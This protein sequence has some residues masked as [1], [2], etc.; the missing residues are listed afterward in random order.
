[1]EQSDFSEPMVRINT[2]PAAGANRWSETQA[3][4]DIASFYRQA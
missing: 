4:D 3:W 1:M 2:E